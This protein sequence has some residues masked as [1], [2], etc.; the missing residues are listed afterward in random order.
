MPD[1]PPKVPIAAE[2]RMTDQCLAYQKCN[3][4]AA[5]SVGDG[6]H[7]SELWLPA[8]VLMLSQGHEVSVRREAMLSTRP[9][10][11]TRWNWSSGWCV[12][13]ICRGDII[14]SVGLLFLDFLEQA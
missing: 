11:H 13:R 10:C 1:R 2:R 3:D 9:A 6:L 14:A 12:S 8:G 4:L 5:E 7:G